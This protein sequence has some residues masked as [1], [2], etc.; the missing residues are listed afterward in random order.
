MTHTF[1]TDLILQV[2]ED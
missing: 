1:K 2:L